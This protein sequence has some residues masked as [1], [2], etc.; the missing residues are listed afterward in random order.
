M[1]PDR[2]GAGLT[3]LPDPEAED[4]GAL[5]DADGPGRVAYV[6]PAGAL[7]ARVP[8][9]VVVSADAAGRGAALGLAAGVSFAVLLSRK[10]IT[11]N[12]TPIPRSVATAAVISAAPMG[13][14]F[15]GG[16]R[17]VFL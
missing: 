12:V 15:F 6:E 11:P 10:V 14:G 16:G 7:L 4:E 9:D 5:A 2:G 1:P 13:F 8:V 17:E 3:S